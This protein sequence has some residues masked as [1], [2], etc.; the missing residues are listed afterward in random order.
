LLR[1]GG[2]EGKREGGRVEGISAASEAETFDL[3]TLCPVL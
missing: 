1:L 2:R 3:W